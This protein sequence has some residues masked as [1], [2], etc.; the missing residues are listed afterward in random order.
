EHL[1]RHPEVVV[2]QQQAAEVVDTL[3]H[4]FASDILRVPEAFRDRRGVNTDTGEYE[5]MRLVADYISGMTDRFAMSR[6]EQIQS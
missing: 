1:Y 2:M 4:H 3:F 5:Q 6:F